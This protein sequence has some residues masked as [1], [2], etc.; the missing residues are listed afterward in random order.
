MWGRG[1]TLRILILILLLGNCLTTPEPQP[2]PRYANINPYTGE[3]SVQAVEKKEP[4]ASKI[5]PFIKPA[6]PVLTQEEEYKLKNQLQELEVIYYKYDKLCPKKFILHG[7]LQTN[8]LSLVTGV[9]SGRLG[10]IYNKVFVKIPI[11][12]SEII[13]RT[14]LGEAFMVEDAYQISDG[15]IPTFARSLTKKQEANCEIFWEYSDKIKSIN[16]QLP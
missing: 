14:N 8:G 12:K 2:K 16:Q 5:P 3:A 7:Q 9:A 1:T 13:G 11:D 15:K 6:K 4:G 10:A